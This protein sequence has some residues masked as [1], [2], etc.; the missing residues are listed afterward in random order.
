MS[1]RGHIEEVLKWKYMNIMRALKQGCAYDKGKY[2]LWKTD[3]GIF[4]L[5]SP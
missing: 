3:L 5:I 4:V 2:L 1:P